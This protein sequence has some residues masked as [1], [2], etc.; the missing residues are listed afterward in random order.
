MRTLRIG[1]VNGARQH[2]PWLFFIIIICLLLLF[3]LVLRWRLIDADVDSYF[4]IY[5][6]PTSRGMNKPL[7]P[8]AISLHGRQPTFTR[9]SLFC[10]SCREFKHESRDTAGHRCS[11]SLTVSCLYFPPP[12]NMTSFCRLAIKTDY[13]HPLLLVGFNKPG[14]LVMSTVWNHLCK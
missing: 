11:T 9:T 8:K 13:F 3:F 6:L 10:H 2:G 7:L 5:L 4:S 14:V 12:K 1:E